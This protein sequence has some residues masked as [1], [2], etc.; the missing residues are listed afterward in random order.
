MNVELSG[1]SSLTATA[2]NTQ[3]EIGA[4]AAYAE[5]F[6]LGNLRVENHPLLIIADEML[7]LPD[8]ETKGTITID[9]IVGW[10][11]IRNMKLS[12]DFKNITIQIA[13]PFRKSVGSSTMFTAVCPI[14]NLKTMDQQILRFGLDTG[15]GFSSISEKA[16]TDDELDAVENHTVTIA[17]V[18]GT[19]QIQSRQITNHTLY[20]SNEQELLVEN[21]KVLPNLTDWATFFEIDGVLGSG[22]FKN[23]ILEIDFLNGMVEVSKVKS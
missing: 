10:N 13:K 4:D 16:L 3:F 20:T 19:R 1:N 5:N 21:L 17:T 12:I 2:D 23:S 15:A 9:G 22:A 14:I 11:A 18:G 7:Q 8:P 6:T